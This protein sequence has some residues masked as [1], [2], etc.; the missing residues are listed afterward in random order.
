MTYNAQ[1]KAISYYLPEKILSNAELL[2]DIEGLN[3][4][5]LNKIG[6]EE[7]R[8]AAPDEFVSELAIKAATSLFEENDIQPDEIEFLILCTQTPDYFLPTTAC[9]VQ[10]KLGLHKKCGA[11]DMNLGCSGF[12]YG[13]CIAS[14]LIQSGTVSNVLLINADTYSRFIHPLDKSTRPIFGDGAA[15]TLIQ[16]SDKKKIGSFI[17]GTDGSG[18]N[19]LIVKTGALR[20]ENTQSERSLF[21]NGPE[22]YKFAVSM[23]PDMVSDALKMNGLTAESIDYFVFHQASQYILDSLKE[24]M[25]IP[26]NKFCNSIRNT[27]NTVSA[28]IPI[29]IRKA[30]EATTIGKGMTLLLAGF[31]VGY[32]WGA[33]VI[34]L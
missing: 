25:R 26:D 24:K 34:E 18:A 28:T 17:L 19:N 30:Q 7:R 5:L 12:I 15:A 3:N 9:L 2:Q 27:G 8:I 14:S 23:V 21:M 10:N 20:E 22:I 1:I 4:K 31:G 11:L 29:A 33:T 6:V 13:L 32:S 16:R